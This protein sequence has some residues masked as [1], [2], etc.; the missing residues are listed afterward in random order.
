MVRI[1][2]FCPKTFLVSKSM[3]HKLIL[4]KRFVKKRKFLV[5]FDFEKINKVDGARI[6]FVLLKIGSEFIYQMIEIRYRTFLKTD[7]SFNIKMSDF[8]IVNDKNKPK[9][10]KKV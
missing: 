3:W 7:V 5:F 2:K 4:V 6:C 1:V 10:A 8:L 9:Y